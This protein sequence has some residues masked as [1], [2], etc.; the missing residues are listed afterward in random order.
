[1]DFLDTRTTS[2]KIGHP[3]DITLTF[4]SL[5]T[6]HV[7]NVPVLHHIPFSASRRYCSKK[8][9]HYFSTVRAERRIESVVYYLLVE[10][11]RV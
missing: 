9:S 1:M 3:Y 5:F 4:L 11:A 2:I 8:V 10:N 6:S 7:I